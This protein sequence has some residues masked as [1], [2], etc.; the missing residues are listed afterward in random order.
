MRRR[1]TASWHAALALAWLVSASGPARAQR[2][3]GGGG[4][5]AAKGEF[6]GLTPETVKQLYRQYETFRAQGKMAP[7]AAP[8]I[9]G[10]RRVIDRI[11]RKRLLV[12]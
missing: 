12:I 9:F 4:A 11:G 3:E 2:Q 1:S 5:L 10:C 6:E 7:S 8:D